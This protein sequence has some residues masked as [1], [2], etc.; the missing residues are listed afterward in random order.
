MK[1]HEFAKGHLMMFIATVFFSFNF[2]ML[3]YMMPHWMNGFDATFFRIVG[4]TVLFWISSMFIK[5]TPII[6]ADWKILFF[7]GIFGIFPFM[8]FFNMALEYSSVIDVSIIMTTPPVLVVIITAIV[9]KMK[10]TFKNGFG[11]FLSIA[12]AIFLIL[13]GKTH[14]GSGRDMM[15]NIYAAISSI[16]YAYY[17]FS[18]RKCSSK[19][20]P[21]SLLRWVFLAASIGAIPLGIIFLG[22]ANIMHHPSTDAILI[23]LCIIFFPS[24]FSFLLIPQ[25]IKRIGQQ[26]VSMYQNLI[27]V[28]ATILAIL[29]K[30]DKLYWDQPVAIVIILL[31][32]YISSVAVKKAK[33]KATADAAAA[34]QINNQNNTQS[35]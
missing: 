29:F 23:L 3:K 16:A 27:P 24:F 26:L 8:V 6:S 2:I 4:A 25:S 1:D 5:R 13:I 17:L 15:G 7:S 21:V 20:H 22:K 14:T 18:I 11:L 10:I 9:D 30:M 34:A 12:G 35:S 32:V 19:Y 28:L 33:D 31:G